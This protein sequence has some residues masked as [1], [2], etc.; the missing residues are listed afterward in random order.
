MIE[1]IRKEFKLMINENEWMDA[2][3]KKEALAKADL[4]EPTIGRLLL[5]TVSCKLNNNSQIFLVIYR[6]S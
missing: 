6:L 1:N 5:L 4:I 2:E 3:S